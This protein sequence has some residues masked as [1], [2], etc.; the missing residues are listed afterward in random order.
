MAILKIYNDI[1]GEQEKSEIKLFTGVDGVCYKDIT[2]FLSNVPKEDKVVDIRIHCRGGDCI[3]GWAMY[4]ALRRSGKEIHTTIEGEC[5]SMATIILLAAPLE[6]RK[7]YKNAHICIH[8]PYS[9]W[10]E[11][12]YPQKLTA[13]AI[14]GLTE[15][16]KIQAE[17]LRDE[18]N[19]ILNLYAQRTNATRTELQELMNKDTFITTERAIELG[20]ISKTLQPNTAKKVTNI[21][22]NPIKK[23]KTTKVETSILNRLFAKVGCRSLKD[24][25]M[26]ALEITTADGTVL[27]VEREEGDPQVGDTAYPD[28]TY[29]LDDGS[30]VV[31]ED[32]LITSITPAGEEVTE[33]ETA[34]VDLEEDELIEKCDELEAEVEKLQ[35]EVDTLTQENDQLK[36]E[37]K[38][39]KDARV[40]SDNEKLIIAKVNRAGG[41]DWL[42]KVLSARSSFTP[43]TKSFR[44]SKGSVATETK[45]QKALRE[46]KEAQEAKRQSRNK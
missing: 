34:Q 10:L 30:T 6:R 19:K 40:L 3:E 11:T 33:K 13:D 14:E 32:S 1:V 16:M 17:S 27:T 21:N 31:V 9:M 42:N 20:F 43:S 2:E 18:Q 26:L 36:E 29:V 7:A 39:K 35:E 45:T 23:M 38:A 41:M 15:Q 24:F 12:D 25:R 28:G 8:N 44:E 37:A 4:D 46:R 5:S 22:F